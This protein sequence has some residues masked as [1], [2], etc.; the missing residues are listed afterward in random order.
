MRHMGY[1]APRG[2][3]HSEKSTGAASHPDEVVDDVDVEGGEAH[4]HRRRPL[5]R[6]EVPPCGQQDETPGDPWGTA[7]LMRKGTV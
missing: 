6:T 4:V 2:R 3:S 1:P 5:Q 7:T